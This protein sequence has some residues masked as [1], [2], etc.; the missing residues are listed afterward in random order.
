MMVI[1]LQCILHLYLY[2][3]VY[4]QLS[5]ADLPEGSLMR[6][7]AEKHKLGATKV[8]NLVSS[9]FA[10]EVVITSELASLYMRLGFEIY[11]V[12]QVCMIT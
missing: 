2:S 7:F 10:E 1:G 11:N 4:L 12:K 3:H 9:Y 6:D 5:R 8:E